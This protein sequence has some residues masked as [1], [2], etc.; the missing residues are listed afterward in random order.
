[1]RRIIPAILAAALLV[2]FGVQ[3]EP[4]VVTD[5]AP[6]TGVRSLGALLDEALDKNPRLRAVEGRYRAAQERLSLVRG[7]PDPELEYEYDRITPSATSMGGGKQTPMKT[8]AVSQEIPFPTKL[9]LRQRIAQREAVSLGAEYEEARRTLVKDVKSAY[10][11][12]ILSRRRATLAAD[13]LGLLQQIASALNTSYAAGKAAPSD[14]LRARAEA[15]RAENERILYEQEARVA[16]SWLA[17]LLG[18]EEAALSAV[19]GTALPVAPILTDGDVVRLAKENRPQL[20]SYRN[21]LEKA[22][23]ERSLSR[24][25]FLPDIKLRYK[26]EDKDGSFREGEWAGS[27]GVTVPLWFWGK[28]AAEV[29]EAKANLQ[30]AEADYQAEENAAVFETK[31]AFARFE[32]ARSMEQVYANGILPQADGAVA[33]ARRAYEAGNGTLADWLEAYKAQRQLQAEYAQAQAGVLTALA[34]LEQVTGAE[35]S[36]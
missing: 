33:S 32:A 31:S 3:A 11:N 23:L 9:F 20:K 16:E 21:L 34:D 29:R 26:R 12:L 7:L 8:L 30:A 25:E 1:M 22:R 5:S 14:I 4:A 24:Q 2:P 19:V 35:L 15:A 13:S 27:V 36:H 18:R 28:Q 6:A 17:S 10:Y